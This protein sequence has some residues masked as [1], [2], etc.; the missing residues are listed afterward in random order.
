MLLLLLLLN[1]NNNK[2]KTT[3]TT[4][5]KEPQLKLWFCVFLSSG[6]SKNLPFV[7]FWFDIVQAGFDNILKLHLD[8]GVVYIFK[9]ALN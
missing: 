1:N 5:V 9:H 2:K 8:F 4:R 3:T 6:I 7:Y